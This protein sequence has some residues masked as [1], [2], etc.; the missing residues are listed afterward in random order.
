M[1][2]TEQKPTNQPHKQTKK[3]MKIEKYSPRILSKT[4]LGSFV[5]QIIVGNVTGTCI[6]VVRLI[7]F[8][9][10]MYTE[11]YKSFEDE[12]ARIIVENLC[13]TYWFLMNYVNI[14]SIPKYCK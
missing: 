5:I 3:Q 8:F 6:S 14:K 12:S 9:Q 1:K 11:K 7:L 4:K 13:R 10:K 2:V